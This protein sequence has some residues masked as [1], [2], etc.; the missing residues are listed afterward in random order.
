MVPVF[1]WGG[2]GKPAPTAEDGRLLAHLLLL[3]GLPGTAAQVEPASAE[4]RAYAISCCSPGW[5]GC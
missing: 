1:G 5:P 3:E 4:P 2:L